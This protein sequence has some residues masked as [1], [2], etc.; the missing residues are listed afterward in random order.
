M[1]G[2]ETEWDSRR[3][4]MRS[5][6]LLALRRTL[7]KPS[8]TKGYFWNFKQFLEIFFPRIHHPIS[9]SLWP[10][11]P[12]M[13]HEFQIGQTLVKPVLGTLRGRTM[14]ELRVKWPRSKST[15]LI[16][17][18]RKLSN[19]LHLNFLVCKI[20]LM[21]IVPISWVYLRIKWHEV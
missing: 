12:L 13:D 4:E 19:F 21:I 2:E 10:C 3:L 1:L 14:Q 8:Q 15:L 16:A 9:Y 5:Q 6:L 18:L 11:K 17:N 7:A 20:E